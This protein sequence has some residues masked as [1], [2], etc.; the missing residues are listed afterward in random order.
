MY[1]NYSHHN[2]RV[3][4]VTENIPGPTEQNDEYE[5]LI[6]KF[7]SQLNQ[8]C[9]CDAN[10]T[11][12]KCSC[13]RLS[14]GL[15]YD[16]NILSTKNIDAEPILE[17]NSF[18]PCPGDCGNRLVQKGPLQGL[19]VNTCN[20]ETKGMGLYTKNAI[21]KGTFICEYAGE[22]ITKTQALKRHK[23]NALQRNMNYIYC[24]NEHSGSGVTQ[25]FIDPSSFGNIGRYINHSCDPNSHIIP[26]R[27]DSP[28]PKLAIFSCKDILSDTEITFD[29]G[30]NNE[31]S[32][33]SQGIDLIHNRKKCLCGSPVCKGI[34]P[35]EIY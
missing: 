14:G 19:I 23:I 17:C 30:S 2:S 10:C 25:T 20:N 12:S 31:F 3:I 5:K 22:V 1:D 27:V 18:C 4:Y 15:N 6:D 34:M 16:N 26:V 8:F 9:K 32:V 21:Q 11:D 33:G 13:I 35:Y 24:L 7:N 29:Y 28:I